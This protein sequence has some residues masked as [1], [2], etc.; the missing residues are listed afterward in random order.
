MG[1]Q[2]VLFLSS[3]ASFSTTF[4]KNCCRG[5]GLRTTTCL[6]V[7]VGLSK[8]ML[9]VKYFCFNKAIFVLMEFHVDHNTV[10]KLR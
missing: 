9:P 1:F 4:L 8:G 5:E 6:K 10:P 3:R 2:D 7:V